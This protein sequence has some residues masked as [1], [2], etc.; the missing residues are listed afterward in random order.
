[1]DILLFKVNSVCDDLVQRK[2]NILCSKRNPRKGK[3][4]D[5]ISGLTRLILMFWKE[6]T[7][8]KCRLFE[9]PFIGL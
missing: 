8:Y 2:L 1:M 9:V 5:Y 4:I 7:P 3:K 6:V